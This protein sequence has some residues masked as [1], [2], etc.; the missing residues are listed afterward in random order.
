MQLIPYLRAALARYASDGTPPFRAL[1]LD[2]PDV[3]A[4]AKTDDAWMVGDRLLVA[5]LFAGELDG[6][7][8]ILPPGQWFDLWSGKAVSGGTTISIPADTRNIPVFVKSGTI[9]P[10]APVTASSADPTRLNLEIGIFGDGSLP[11][12]LETPAR[13]ASTSSNSSGGLREMNETGNE[14]YTVSKWSK[15]DET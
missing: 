4:L 8:L 12:L 3:P 9:L 6:R 15:S 13:S 7:K 14:K 2:W 5:P 11:F 1:A 10:I